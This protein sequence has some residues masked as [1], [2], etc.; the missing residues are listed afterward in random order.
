MTRKKS[1]YTVTEDLSD[2]SQNLTIK[3]DITVIDALE[4]VLK[5][6]KTTG[7]RERTLYDYELQINHFVK[8]TG[9][10][11]ISEVT[12]FH[13]YDWLESMNVSNNTKLTRLKCLKAFFN[14]CYKLGWFSSQF[15]SDVKIK[16]DSPIKEGA[17]EQNVNTLLGSLDLNDFF[18]LRDATAILTMYQTG[19]RIGT[20]SKI[21]EGHIDLAEKVF[22]IP[23]SIVKNHQE[24]I[25]PFDDVLARLFMALFKHNAI[26]RKNANRS[27]Q[28]VFITRSGGSSQNTTMNN[29]VIT[30]RIAY[31]AKKF[32]IENVNPH[33]LRRGFAVNLRKKGANI[34][35]ISN[36]LGH[37]DLAVTTRY[38]HYD[39]L[40]AANELRDFLK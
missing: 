37:N 38:L 18:Q 20:L 28:L 27:N 2:V 8:I 14:R 15:W 33:A 26:V 39:K 29:N 10:V 3:S 17:T 5:Q 36:A 1:I 34:S 30:K 7:C 6:M 24:L 19:I 21:T 31:Y 12:V 23:G 9:V 11:N 4:I 35:L 32:N 40:Q 22:R 16:V 13:I 25:L